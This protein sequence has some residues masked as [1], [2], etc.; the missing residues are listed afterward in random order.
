MSPVA[1][2][3]DP[4]AG[5]ILLALARA[6]IAE[7]FGRVEK[8][9]DSASWLAEPGAVFVTLSQGGRLRGC[10]GSL[11]AHRSLASDV[12]HN[13]RAA[14][15]SD[16]RFPPLTADELPRTRIE[17]SVLSAPEPLPASTETEL[18][19]RLR[20]GVDGLILSWGGHRGTFLPQVWEQLP[21]PRD[22]WTHLKRKAGLPLSFWS[23]DALIQRYT[24]TA[25]TEPDNTTAT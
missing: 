17:V 18:L 8:P 25:W 9:D 22:F 3:S 19:A 12:A 20:P 4:R 23:P 24:V 7:H 14:A 16:P 6:A 10:I 21:E 5:E 11:E 2:E 1:W 15:F 13:A